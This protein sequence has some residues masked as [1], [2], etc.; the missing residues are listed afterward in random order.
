MSGA[1][2]LRHRI[3]AGERVVGAMVFEF[4]SPG[5]SRILA[6]AGAQ[7]VI[8]DMEHSGLEFETL[9]WLFATCRGLPI[10]PMVRVP[11]SDYTWIARSLDLGARGIMVP[12][13]ETREQALDI[14]QSCRYPLTGRRGAGFGFAQC[15]YT[16]GDVIAKMADY[17]QRTLV[18]AQIETER[19]LENVDAIAA[20]EG[21]D[22]LWVG[23][24][25]LSNFM[26]LPAQFDHPE[27]DRALRHVGEVAHRH[28]KVAA[29][30]ATDAA[31]MARARSM[32]YTLLAAGT[33]SGLLQAAMGD[34]IRQ[35]R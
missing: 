24:F 8:Y 26:G 23:H 20:V 34:L 18:I 35:A 10:E 25:D 14:V 29:I 6:N 28:G 17:H 22:A 11:R 3:R 2:N 33:D 16:G 21:I 15:D 9:K 31:W 12:M 7:F 30:M 1:T 32:G 13:V 19:G 4:F 27:F 5:M